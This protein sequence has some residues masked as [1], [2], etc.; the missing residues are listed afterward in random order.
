M[1]FLMKNSL[2]P[3][4]FKQYSNNFSLLV[5][6]LNFN[7]Q[8]KEALLIQK[9]LSPCHLSRTFHIW[10]GF[11]RRHSPIKFGAISSIKSHH[12]PS[13]ISYSKKGRFLIST[14]SG[15]IFASFIATIF[16]SRCSCDQIDLINYL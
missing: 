5:F 13:L 9:S 4:Y 1:A 10:T 16:S 14:Y 11:F 12:D 3:L 15:N 6:S 2:S 8:I 7:W